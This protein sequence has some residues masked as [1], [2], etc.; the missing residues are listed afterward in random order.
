MNIQNVMAHWITLCVTQYI[1]KPVASVMN[2][3]GKTPAISKPCF[4]CLVSELV[5]RVLKKL[6]VP[7]MHC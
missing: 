7:A 2:R 3:K 6:I 1:C 4:A 5:M